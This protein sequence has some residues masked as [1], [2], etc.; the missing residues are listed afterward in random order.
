MVSRHVKESLERYVDDHIEPG[1]FLRAVLE[2]DLRESFGRADE[3]NRLEL[4]NIVMYIYSELPAICWGSKK[5]V[6]GWL[7]DD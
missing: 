5:K 3:G 4:F 1:G 2:N 6:D 7:K